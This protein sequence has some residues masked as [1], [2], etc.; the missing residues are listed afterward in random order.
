MADKTLHGVADRATDSDAFEYT[1]RAGFVTS[2][3][4]H[5]LVA[6]IIIRIAFGSGGN[7]DQSGALATLA[8]QTGGT[9]ILWV[10]AVGLVALGLWRVAEAIVGSKPGEGSGPHED[11]TPAWKR[12]KSLG[13]AI[14][15][16]AIALSAARFAMG[17]GQ[18][19][20]QQN[21]G[22]S[23]QLM[24][25]GWGKALLIAVGLG[26][27]GVGGYHVYKGVSKKFLKDLRVSGGTG[28]NAVGITG[29]AA[30]GLVLAG[31]GV[32]VIVATLQ[33]DP[34]KAAGLDAAVKTLGQAPFG[35]F[36]LILAALGIAAFGAYS[37]VR[38]RFGRM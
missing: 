36:L 4:L 20:S 6:F 32:L 37:F 7:A 38:A 33:A 22:M 5:L 14:V 25:S 9:L 18:Q 31:A 12:G 13:L 23:A 8:N 2:G 11:D 19:S 1:A 24:Q 15:N 30:K 16:F 26:L 17:S 10:A 34:S 28:I 29:Y 27:A 35:K 3:V 21:T